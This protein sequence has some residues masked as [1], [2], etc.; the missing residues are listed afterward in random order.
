MAPREARGARRPAAGQ[1][2]R[3]MAAGRSAGRQSPR[4]G[5]CRGSAAARGRPRAGDPSA[6]VI[7]RLIAVVTKLSQ[8]ASRTTGDASANRSD[9]S[10]IAR[11]TRVRTGSPRKSAKR[12]AS[13]ATERSPQRPEPGGARLRAA[14]HPPG[15]P[16]RRAAGWIRSRRRREEPEAGEDGL[17]VGP[18]EPG[19]ERL[20]GGVLRR[21]DNDAVIHGNH[22]GRVRDG[23]GRHLG[24]R[25]RVGDVDD[26]GVALA[27][28]RPWPPR[29]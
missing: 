2:R 21:C 6:T 23:D 11:P 7:A 18:G 5:P 15:I 24:R 12:A 29:R 8:S 26:S 28:A 9:P 10:R 19:Q 20:G 16:G 1:G 14:A 3:P 22:V 27:R 17:A 4:P 13:A 25:L